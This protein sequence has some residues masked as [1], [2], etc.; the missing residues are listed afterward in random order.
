V[1][2]LHHKLDHLPFNVIVE[3]IWPVEFLGKVLFVNGELGIF[4]H[5]IHEVAYYC[6]VSDS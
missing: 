3:M 6:L 2:S 5:L 4:S 1:K